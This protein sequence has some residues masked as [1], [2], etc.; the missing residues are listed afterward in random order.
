MATLQSRVTHDVIARNLNNYKK[1][2]KKK[3]NR[4]ATSRCTMRAG[5]GR[6]GRFTHI[7]RGAI[8]N[9]LWCRSLAVVAEY[10]AAKVER[11]VQEEWDALPHRLSD[12]QPEASREKR[13]ILTMFPYP[14]GNLHMGHVRVY[15]Y[16]DCLARF[17]RMLGRDVLHPMGWDAFGLPA[18]NAARDR[19]MDPAVWTRSNIDH[20]R[21]QLRSLGLSCEWGREISTCDPSYYRWTQWLFLSLWRNGLC[22]QA[23]AAVNWD[24]VDQTVLANEQVDAEGRSWRSGAVV[25]RRNLRQWFFRITHYAAPLLDAL[26]DREGGLLQGWPQQ[27][28]KMQ[29][30]WIGASTGLII[31]FGSLHVFTTRPETLMGC[32]FVAVAEDHPAAMQAGTKE[33]MQVPHPLTGQMLPVLIAPHVLSDYASGAVMGVPAHDERDATFAREKG[34]PFIQ[35]LNKSGERLENSGPF[36]GLTIDEAREA[37][38]VELEKRD[39]GKRHTA[40]R[41]RD[42][43]VSRQRP[44]GA[45]IPMVHCAKCGPVPVADADLPVPLAP[46]EKGPAYDAWLSCACPKCGGPGTRDTDTM[47]TFVDSSW[48]FLRYTSPQDSTVPSRALNWMPVDTYI[49]GVEHAVLHLLYA[50][51]INRFLH[52]QGYSPT[53]EPFKALLTQGMVQSRTYR[54]QGSEKPVPEKDVDTT[55]LIH[56]LTGEKVTVTWEKMSKSKLNGV[57]PQ[58]MVTAYGADATR[59]YVMFRAPPHMA[60]E[61]DESGIQGMRRWLNR[62]WRLVSFQPGGSFDVSAGA[63]DAKALIS[64]CNDVIRQVRQDL[65]V[66]F[67]FNTAIAALMT[68]SNELRM[69]VSDESGATSSLVSHPSWSKSREALVVMLAPLAPHFAHEAWRMLGH[70]DGVS[71]FQQ[72]WP[73]EIQDISGGEDKSSSKEQRME[74]TVLVDGKKRGTLVVDAKILGDEQQL[75]EAVAGEDQL[76]KWIQ[77][78]R[79]S[80]I[81]RIDRSNMLNIVLTKS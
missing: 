67:A 59:L 61:W 46:R 33:G 60:L 20:M 78:D 47:D 6:I 21:M 29:Q 17:H 76:K 54:L 80:K 15:T 37:I 10:D 22:Y 30:L 79:I 26:E 72:P 55:K 34:L 43:L 25:E 42:W 63:R 68:L 27:V 66:R 62:L 48:Y 64:L 7:Q 75:I 77:R 49:G 5:L 74:F 23:D 53:P 58:H 50:R 81:I 9:Q 39:L 36:S 12:A 71:V 28:K 11:R 8:F 14:S 65:E 45:P 13:Y 19:Q 2:Q 69:H 56:R 70:Q 32:T 40:Y 57:D 38:A 16:G 3:K 41:L 31:R 18:E 44:W 4:R 73:K 51:F 35:V 1:Q 52:E 24:P